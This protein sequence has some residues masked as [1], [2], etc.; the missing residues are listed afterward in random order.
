MYEK[1][2]MLECEALDL[3]PSGLNN[4]IALE[5]LNPPKC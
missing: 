4:L 3:F 2:K 1:I 5:E